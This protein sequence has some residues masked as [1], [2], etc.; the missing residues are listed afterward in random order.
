M[1]VL[2]IVSGGTDRQIRIFDAL[3]GNTLHVLYGHTTAV[4]DLHVLTVQGETCIASSSIDST[5]RV[6][7]PED[8]VSIEGGYHHA[9][10]GLASITSID[11]NTGYKVKA[12]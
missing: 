10:V 2:R 11:S 6:W 12:S 9:G 7:N 5:V 8:G 3:S 1:N 4:S